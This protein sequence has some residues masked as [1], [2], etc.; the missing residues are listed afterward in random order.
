[1]DCSGSSPMEDC[2][3]TPLPPLFV[4]S[5]LCE[6]PTSPAG[7][8]DYGGQGTRCTCTAGIAVGERHPVQA[9]HRG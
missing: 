7:T 6:P 3:D 5:V 1:M 4:R 2:L 9:G 8:S